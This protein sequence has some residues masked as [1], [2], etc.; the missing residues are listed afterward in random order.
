MDADFRECDTAIP[1]QKFAALF[2]AHSADRLIRNLATEVCT[3]TVGTTVLPVT[4][5]DGTEPTCYVCCPSAA[6]VDYAREEL[7]TLSSPALRQAVAALVKL[8]APL[9]RATTFDRQVQPNNWLLATNIQPPLASDEIAGA[10]RALLQRWPDRAI[11]WRSLNEISD[12]QALEDFRAARYGLYPAR[13]IY[14]FDCREKPIRMHR[15]EKRDMALLA[16]SD[17]RVEGPADI[18]AEDFERIEALYAC[19]YLKKYT[20]LNPQYTAGFLREMHEASLLNVFGLRNRAGRLDGVIAFFEQRDVM[21]APV[22]GYDTAIGAEVGLYRRLM[23][24][25]L[26]RG[27]EK[28]LLFNMSAGA[29]G[30][31]RNRGGVPAIEYAAVYDRHLPWRNRVTGGIIRSILNGVGVP[32]MRKLK[33]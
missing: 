28:R 20:P 9:V 16:R 4:V 23:A 7:R 10:T 14:L 27:R 30:F 24:I 17:Y 18:L 6:Y 31:K 22:V 21:T 13:Q 26:S 33:L 15:D 3:L 25:A 32:I 12:R 11:V 8:S 1:A 2:R 29:A 19:L 5:N